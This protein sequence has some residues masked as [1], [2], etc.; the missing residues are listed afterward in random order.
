METIDR[1]PVQEASSSRLHT[2]DGKGRSASKVSIGEVARKIS[3]VLVADT[4]VQRE[5]DA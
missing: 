5:D 2:R 1:V 4:E 3:T